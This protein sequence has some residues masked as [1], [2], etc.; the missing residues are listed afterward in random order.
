M[1]GDLVEFLRARLDEDEQLARVATTVSPAPWR[2]DAA[3]GAVRDV[4][5]TEVAGHWRALPALAGT[6]GPDHIVRHDPTRALADVT[7]KRKVV[8]LAE[9]ATG[10]DMQV[11]S[12]FRVG[13]RDSEAEPYVGD[14]ILRQLALPYA[15][16]PD[17]DE[18]WRP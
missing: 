11:D 3:A 6:V 18:G 14:L 16:H 17:Y 15:S 2:V 8:E 10:L 1:T 5:G 9:E 12:E 7:A 4:H 13:S